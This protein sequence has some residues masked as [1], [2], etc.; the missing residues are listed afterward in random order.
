MITDSSIA[1]DAPP[2]V[3]WETF[4]DVERWPAWT[5]SVTSLRALDGAD[6]ETGARFEI[7][8]PRFPRLTWT[9]TEVDPG[10]SWTW[11]SKT[12]GNTTLASHWVEA[13]A[14]GSTLVRQRIDQRGPGGVLFGVLFRGLTRK[15]LALEGEG[16]KAASERRA[17]T[18]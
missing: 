12:V 2:S 15:Y 18:A 4:A 13:Q 16:L 14:D 5:A 1:I 10:R 8:Q 7:K 3:V 9:V 17:A 6:L 11:R